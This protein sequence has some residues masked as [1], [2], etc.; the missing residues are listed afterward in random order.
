MRGH[1]CLKNQV[2][3]WDSSIGKKLIK[4]NYI[5]ICG[6][7]KNRA[8]LQKKS[9]YALEC[10]YKALEQSEIKLLV[11]SYDNT[12][13]HDGKIEID[14]CDFNCS[15]LI[16]IDRDQ[17]ISLYTF[18]LT[19]GNIESQS[20]RVLEQAFY[21][22]SGTAIADAARD[23]LAIWIKKQYPEDSCYVSHC[24]GPGFFGMPAIDT[25]KFFQFMECSKIG[26]TMLPSG[27]MMPPKSCAGFYLVTKE[28]SDLP[29][30]DCANCMVKGKQCNYCRAGRKHFS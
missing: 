12:C 16:G 4:E 24:F 11:S 9:Q 26:L 5:D 20:A 15:S 27:F 18:V 17:I 14:G 1:R 25:A 13:I 28:K 8:A 7:N 19:A 30:F 22:I 10:L 29:E 6:L 2:I 21:D 23:M 3:V